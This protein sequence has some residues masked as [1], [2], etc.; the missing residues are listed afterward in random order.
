MV[1]SP[2]APT[3]AQQH[4]RIGDF[5][6]LGPNIT[7]SQLEE[8]L[9]NSSSGDLTDGKLRPQGLLPKLATG[10]LYFED[11]DRLP[12]SAQRRLSTLCQER[13]FRRSGESFLRRCDTA[14]L[15]PRRLLRATP[16]AQDTHRY[17]HGYCTT[18]CATATRLRRFHSGNGISTRG[19]HGQDLQTRPVQFSD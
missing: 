14:L 1:R 6:K 4:R 11:V 10:S 5:V 13:E 12:L 15:S 7:T 9:L 19:T 16:M 8:E 2:R 18:A 17:R 3:A